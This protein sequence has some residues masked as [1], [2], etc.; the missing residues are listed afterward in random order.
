MER[1]WRSVLAPP[2]NHQYLTFGEVFSVGKLQGRERMQLELENEISKLL[3][4]LNSKDFSK[5]RRV[6]LQFS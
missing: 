2:E 5:L 4:N 3:S 1:F 6:E